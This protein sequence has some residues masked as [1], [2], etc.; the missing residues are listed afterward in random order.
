MSFTPG[1]I[2]FLFQCSEG[3][4]RQINNICDNAMLTAYAAGESIIGRQ[5]IEEVADNLD[6]LPRK[7]NLIANMNKSEK[8]AATP[9]VLTDNG[10]EELYN[11]QRLSPKNPR[12]FKPTIHLEIGDQRN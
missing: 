10:R 3:I 4:P 12:C 5:I 8:L 6:M 9:R 7:D 11:N 2:D 1:A